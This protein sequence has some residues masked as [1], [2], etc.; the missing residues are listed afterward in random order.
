MDIENLEN[1]KNKKDPYIN[2]VDPVSE[3]IKR[4]DKI[5]YLVIGIFIVSL[6]VMIVM[7]AT[8]IID[9]FHFNSAVYQEYSDKMNEQNNM[10]DTNKTLL[11]SNKNLLDTVKQNQGLIKAL[12]QK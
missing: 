9:S 12:I 3:L 1:K 11:D 6:T 4:Y 2:I 5:I 10:L 8:L 7:V